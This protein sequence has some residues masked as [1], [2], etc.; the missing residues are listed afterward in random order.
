M[1]TISLSE[2]EAGMVKNPDLELAQKRFLLTL[3][4]DVVSRQEKAQ[5]KTE[6]LDAVAKDSATPPRTTC[7]TY[8]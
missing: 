8:I 4:D 1:S 5:L 3:H 2:E 7:R 6:L